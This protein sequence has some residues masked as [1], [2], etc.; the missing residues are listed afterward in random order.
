MRAVS[1]RQ[2][3]LWLVNGKKDYVDLSHKIHNLR[4]QWKDVLKQDREGNGKQ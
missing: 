1:R 2:E 3:F 4:E